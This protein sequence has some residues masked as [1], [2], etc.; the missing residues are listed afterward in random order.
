MPSIRPIFAFLALCAAASAQLLPFRLLDEPLP[1]GAGVVE[2]AADFNNDG[3]VDLLTSSGILVGDGHANFVAAP[4]TPLAAYRLCTRVADLNGDGLTDVVSVNTQYIAMI[5]F[6]AGGFAF[7]PATPAF[8]AVTAGG[9]SL[10]PRWLAPGD[11]DGDG[12][13]DVLA[14]M[15]APVGQ[16]FSLVPFTAVL[17]VNGGT[18]TFTVAPAAA[19]PIGT[20]LPREQELGDFD[21]DGDLDIILAGN[22]FPT[23]GAVWLM[24]NSGTGVFG[25]PVTITTSSQSLIK[26]AVGDFNGD[27][28]RDATVAN[29][30]TMAIF[31]GSSTGL[32]PAVISPMPFGAWGMDAV[33]L[34]QDGRDELLATPAGGT[35]VTVFPVSAAGIVG[36]P[37]QVLPGVFLGV[38]TPGPDAI[39]DY[40]GDGDREVPAQVNGYGRSV[41]F[42]NDGLGCSST[43]P[44]DCRAMHSQSRVA[45]DIDADGDLDLVGWAL[46][47]AIS[48][49]VNDGDGFFANGPVSAVVPANNGLNLLLLHAFDRDGDGDD[50][51]YGA[52]NMSS[53]GY[54]GGN[55]MVWDAAAGSFSTA[56]TLA[57]N[58]PVVAIRDFDADGDGDRDI[59]LG[60][61]APTT[62]GNGTNVPPMSLMVNLGPAGF[63]APMTVGGI[64]A[65]YDLEIADFDGNGTADVFQTNNNFIGAFDPCVL[66]L[67]NGAG[68]FTAHVQ[69]M[70]GFYSATGDLDGNGLPDLVIDGQVWFNA[71]GTSFVAGPAITPAIGGPPT[72]AD[73]DEDGDL[74]LVESP[75]VVRDNLGGGVFAAPVSQLPY[76]PIAPTSWVVPTSIVADFDR[77]GGP[78]VMGSDGRMHMNCSRQIALGARARPG[79]PASLDLYGPPGGAFALYVSAGTAAFF[80]P[81]YGT[82]LIDPATAILLHAGGF[83]PTGAAVPGFASLQATLPAQP[84]LVG[85]TLYWQMLDS[86]ARLSNR[87]T[88]TIAGY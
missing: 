67:N 50:D 28:I 65:T 36:A 41:L 38:F 51:L 83:A 42:M 10:N 30:T 15:W 49:M 68:T 71:G 8:P 43:P 26:P 40:D 80:L 9:V 25:A 24:T 14:L 58:G 44:A 61:R 87:I 46:L 59:L 81:P 34:N 47:G 84:S 29:Y 35:G 55:D 66:Y 5:E 11:V 77:D 52:R 60:K 82:V 2:A 6:N 31:L 86:S 75:A 70:I 73:V 20:T 45:G 53:L 72:L 74:D 69:T 18:G 64:H 48:T 33:D 54:P 85:L 39:A 32:S 3:T 13:V 63:A 27:G 57:D 4:G 88:T 79:R 7:A 62:T 56:F 76:W 12:D 1:P 23:P 16:H 37:T 21:A 17:F 78:D 22:A 19:F